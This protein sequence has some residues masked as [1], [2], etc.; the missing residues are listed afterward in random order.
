MYVCTYIEADLLRR[1]MAFNSVV[2]CASK[3]QMVVHHG[4]LEMSQSVKMDAQLPLFILFL[5]HY[6][7][8]NS[9]IS[10]SRA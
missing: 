3:W 6:I 4:V 5:R 8:N 2:I 9:L 7:L 1:L 10:C